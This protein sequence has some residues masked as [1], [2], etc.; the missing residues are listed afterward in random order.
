MGL[1]IAFVYGAIFFV[2]PDKLGDDELTLKQKY[3]PRPGSTSREAPA[4]S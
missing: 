3:T 1:L 2:A 4:S